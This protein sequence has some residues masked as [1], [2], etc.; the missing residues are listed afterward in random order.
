MHRN[1]M[2]FGIFYAAYIIWLSAYTVL[3]AK[4][5][6]L[7]LDLAPLHFTCLA[8]KSKEQKGAFVTCSEFAANWAQ[9]PVY[10]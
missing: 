6:L 8:F 1:A 4:F 5:L 10:F 2:C 3:L 9:I 7:F